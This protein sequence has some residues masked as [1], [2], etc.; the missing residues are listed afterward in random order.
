MTR[1]GGPGRVEPKNQ[2]LTTEGGKRERVWGVEGETGKLIFPS[3][4]LPSH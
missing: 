2:S 4:D 1:A 3:S